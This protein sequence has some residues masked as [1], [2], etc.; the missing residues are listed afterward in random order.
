M[1]ELADVFESVFY[2]FFVKIAVPDVLE[3]AQDADI[4]IFVLPHQF[5]KHT[6]KPL[7]GKLKPGACGLS[8]I[9]VNLLISFLE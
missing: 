6:C 7:I 5:I 3:T 9:K 1:Y 4:L 2:F 8:L